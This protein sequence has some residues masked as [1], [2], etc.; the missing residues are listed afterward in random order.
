MNL[1]EKAHTFA[2]HAHR[3]HFR[4]YTNLPY[5]THLEAVAHMV[6]STPNATEQMVAAA[7]LHDC[8][9]D[10]GITL[11][12]LR[13]EF[14]HTIAIYVDLLTDPPE[15]NRAQRKAKVIQRLATAPDKVKTIKL[16]DL[17]DNTSTITLYDP[18][19]A[20]VYMNEKRQLLPV[21]VGGD[22]ELFE[23]ASKLVS[24]YFAQ[25]ED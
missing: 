7:L 10:V 2:E 12:T 24:T 11:D 23:L 4:K 5:L 15:G 17:I 21:L 8:V 16:A 3:N 19:F 6:A 25:H 18:K 20:K 9:E 1:I 13:E 14:G 22:T